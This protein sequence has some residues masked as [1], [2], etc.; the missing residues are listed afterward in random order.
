MGKGTGKRKDELHNRSEAFKRVYNNH[1][2]NNIII[3]N[4]MSNENALE[5][6]K[7]YIAFYW[8]VGE[9][10]CNFTPGGVGFA[11]GSLNPNYHRDWTGENNP[12][13]GRSHSDETKRKISKNRKGKGSR[14]GKDNPMFGKGLK[15]EE[16]PMFGRTGFKHPNSKMY[17]VKY[18][19]GEDEFLSAKQ[20]AVK[21]G[22]AFSRI[23]ENGGFLRYR[24]NTKSKELYEGLEL[25]QVK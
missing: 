23:D 2:C 6:E 7:H 14:S 17:K 16:N 21:F 3:E 5:R 1:I 11:K 18:K 4:N 19:N 9:A 12:F 10:E 13:Y 15:G 25:I 22:I 20:C 8:S 24:S